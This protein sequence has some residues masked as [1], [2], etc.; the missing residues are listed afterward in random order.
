MPPGRTALR[1]VA[2]Y[3]FLCRRGAED[4]PRIATFRGWL[5][6]ELAGIGGQEADHE[7]IDPHDA[8]PG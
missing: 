5:I 3:R 1:T 2:Q 7:V 4:H 6:A 8:P